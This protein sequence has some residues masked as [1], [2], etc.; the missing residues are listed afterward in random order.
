MTQDSNPNPEAESN[1]NPAEET[2]NVEA[3][4]VD[5]TNS[6]PEPAKA[7]APKETPKATP[8]PESPKAAKPEPKKPATPK[9]TA[10]K[11]ASSASE[12]AGS[13]MMDQVKAVA[14]ELWRQAKPV[15]QKVG[16][17]A[18]LYG[19]K[20]TDYL[21]D[22]GFPLAKEKFIQVLPADFK[23]K[24]QEKIDPVKEKV[25]PVWQ[26]VCIPAGFESRLH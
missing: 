25:V 22:T 12:D 3:Q 23:T 26:K 15:L 17:Q 19:N 20:A 7:E 2:V 9:A 6:A 13:E 21:L 4:A 16:T 14:S 11:T 1:N 8:A 18:L 10:P 5:E 24:A